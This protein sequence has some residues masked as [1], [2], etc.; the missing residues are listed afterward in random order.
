VPDNFPRLK[1]AIARL[2]ADPA[3]L[4]T[5]VS[6]EKEHYTGLSLTLCRGPHWPAWS[7]LQ[8]TY[9]VSVVGHLATIDEDVKAKTNDLKGS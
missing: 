6:L 3:R 7:I 5:Q 9:A 4:L 8:R 1:V 2:N